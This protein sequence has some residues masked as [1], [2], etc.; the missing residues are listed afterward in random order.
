MMSLQQAAAATTGQV[1]GA[2]TCFARV[3]SD[4][5]DAVTES[6]FVALRGPSFDGHDFAAQAMAAGAAACMLE[7]PLAGLSPVLLVDDC[8]A[9]LG[10]LAAAW[11]Q[12]L[13]AQVCAITGSN[14]KTT[15]KEMLATILRQVAPITSTR[16]NRNNEIGLP[17]TLL[18]IR[19]DDRYAVLEMGMNHRGEIAR[20]SRWAVPNVAVITN[21]AAAHL[22]GLD[23]VAGV[24]AAKA[25]IFQGLRADGIAVLNA[26]SPFAAYWEQQLSGQKILRFGYADTADIRAI[27]RDQQHWQL[28]IGTDTATI[29][30]QL[31]GRHNRY[32]ALAAAAAAHALGLDITCIA[33]GLAASKPVPGRMQLHRTGHGARLYDDSYN[34][35]PESFLAA[36]EVL[37]EEPGKRILVLGDMAELGVH[38]AALHAECGHRAAALGID[39]VFG[40]G[41]EVEHTC[42]AFG[43]QASRFTD[44]PALL[45][46][47]R[48]QLDCHTVVL[49]KGSRCMQMEAVVTALCTTTAVTEV[50]ASC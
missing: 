10:Q 44:L 33:H 23:D 40:L 50:A 16:G 38:S 47:L 6:L 34:A 46:A 49:V 48:P 20:L 14:G 12:R 45:L 17:L 4:T 24:A 27:D 36:L 22:A 31:P 11:R 42:R 29:R 30:L 43:D 25:E 15:V 7:R 8:R 41:V 13:P 1:T 37:A 2:E 19:P 28:C 39:Q 32:N 21:A 9:A 18:Q 5:R 35:N 26:D 3:V